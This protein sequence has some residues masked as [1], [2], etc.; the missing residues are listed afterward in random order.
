M[1]CKIGTRMNGSAGPHSG[2]HSVVLVSTL[3]RIVGKKDLPGTNAPAY[4]VLES[5]FTLITCSKVIEKFTDVK[6]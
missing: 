5:F 2:H 3:V 6:Y 4:L 1:F